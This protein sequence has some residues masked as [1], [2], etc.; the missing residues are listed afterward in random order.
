MEVPWLVWLDGASAGRYLGSKRE[1]LFLFPA[2]DVHFN[3]HRPHV[4]ELA[5]Q[6]LR[7]TDDK[8]SRQAP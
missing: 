5:I 1:L 2:G 7:M 3:Q 8:F 6:T 4:I